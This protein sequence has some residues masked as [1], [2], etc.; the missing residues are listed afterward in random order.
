MPPRRPRWRGLEPR[1]PRCLPSRLRS[2]SSRGCCSRRGA[3]PGTNLARR[4]YPPV[5]CE[6]CRSGLTGNATTLVRHYSRVL[7]RGWTSCVSGPD[8]TRSERTVVH[9]SRGRCRPGARR[10]ASRA[11]GRLP[12]GSPRVT[13]GSTL[14]HQ[15]PWAPTAAHGGRSRPSG[16]CLPPACEEAARAAYGRHVGWSAARVVAHARMMR[17]GR[18]TGVYV[19]RR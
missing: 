6:V 1:R 13:G 3:R 16:T 8:G 10:L 12:S 17:L 18:T 15:R 11:T 5:I 4:S 9:R 14:G 19:K 2:M 7:S